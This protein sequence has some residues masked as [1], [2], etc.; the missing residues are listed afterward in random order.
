[1]IQ[2]VGSVFF[3]SLEQVGCGITDSEAPRDIVSALR[4]AGVDVIVV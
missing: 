3:A 1:M 4:A 2:E